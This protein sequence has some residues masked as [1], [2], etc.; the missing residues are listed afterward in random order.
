[1]SGSTNGAGFGGPSAPAAMRCRATAASGRDDGLLLHRGTVRGFARVGPRRGKARLTLA[2]TRAV[3]GQVSAR[4]SAKPADSPV[5]MRLRRA[6][7]TVPGMAGDAGFSVGSVDLV[8]VL[9]RASARR[10][11]WLATFVS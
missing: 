2:T 7:G 8:L 6:A 1:M 4:V 10:G 3:R 11:R 9:R 5:V